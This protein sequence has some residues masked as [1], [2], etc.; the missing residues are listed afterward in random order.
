MV[1][2]VPGGLCICGRSGK[3][4]LR[5]VNMLGSLLRGLALHMYPGQGHCVVLMGKVLFFLIAP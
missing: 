1:V 5:M 4:C 2:L 3:K